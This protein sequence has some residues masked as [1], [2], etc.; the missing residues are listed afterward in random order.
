MPGGHEKPMSLIRKYGETDF[1]TGLRAIA[2]TMVVVIHTGAFN[3]FGWLGQNVTAAGKHGVQA[4]FVIS[5]FTIV[6][7]F[8]RSRSYSEYLT[9][10]LFRIAPLYYVMCGLAAVLIASAVLP[11]PYWMDRYGSSS[12]LYNLFA[13][14]SFLSFLDHRV[15]NSLIG[16]EWSIPIEV[17]AYI[18]LPF[19]IP[20]LRTTKDY[21][22]AFVTLLILSGLSRAGAELFN[23][24]RAE[25]FP[26]TFGPYFLLGMACHAIRK[27]NWRDEWR[28]RKSAYWGGVVLFAA[29]LLL[30]L[31]GGS[32]LIAL[33]TATMITFHKTS[34]SAPGIQFLSTRPMLFVG[35]ISYSIYLWHILIMGLF[36]AYV[37]PGNGV[38]GLWLFAVVYGATLVASTCS[39]MLIEKPTNSWGRWVADRALPVKA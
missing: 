25:W 16:V 15:A 12:G 20:R 6:A 34:D 4:F 39:Y 27:S 32:A 9:R 26:L 10:R 13:H 1:I 31:P 18:F 37:A 22:I 29:T 23:D 17:F 8:L 28:Y 14:L 38:T 11:V 24:A 30:G 5:G 21:R 33:A 35:S 7:T 2:A 19:L 36:N 3:D